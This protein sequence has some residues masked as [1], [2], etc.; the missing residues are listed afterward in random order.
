MDTDRLELLDKIASLYY[1]EGLSQA[2]IAA[3]TGYSPSMISRLLTE[4]RQQGVVEIRIH[5]PI[6]RRVDLEQELQSLLNLKLVRVVMCGT[7]EFSQMLRRLGTMAARLV[8]DQAHDNMTVGV[9]WGTAVYETVTALR[10]G[11]DVGVSVVQMIGSLDTPHP[12]IS[13]PELTQQLAR[14][15]MGRYTILPAPLLVDSEAT[16]QS[17][18]NDSRVRHVMGEFRKIELALI[19]VGSVAPTERS[20]LQRAGYIT[21]EQAQELQAAGAVGD[22]CAIFFDIQGRLINLPLTRRIVG[23]DAANLSAIPVKIGVGGGPFKRAPIIGASRAG[24]INVLV[25]DD[26][27]AMGILQDIQGN[28]KD[29]NG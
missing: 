6:P 13:G 11:S 4:A 22:V 23:I 26:L 14:I 19:G 15:L 25:T 28:G 12:E 20:A 8:E 29:G 3:K 9:S 27:T 24:L 2:Q 1:E 10:M 18:L 7:L 16:R 17:L 5:H 21:P